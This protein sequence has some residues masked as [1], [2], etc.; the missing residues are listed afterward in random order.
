M[1]TYKVKNFNANFASLTVFYD[2]N[3][4]KLKKKEFR[5]FSLMKW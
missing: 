1:R 5:D 2:I 3:L 4:Q